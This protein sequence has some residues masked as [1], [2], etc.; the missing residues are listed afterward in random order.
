MSIDKIKNKLIESSKEDNSWVDK[1]KYRKANESWLDISFDIAIYVM[2]VLKTNKELGIKPKTQKDLAELLDCTPQ[3]VNKI[4]KGTEKLQIDTICKI[5]NILK[6]KLI[7]ITNFKIED[8]ISK[9]NK[10]EPYFEI[11]GDGNYFMKSLSEF[12]T[13]EQEI[14]INK[15]LSPID[16]TIDELTI[17]AK[18]RREAMINF[19]YKFTNKLNI[20]IDEIEKVPAYKRMMISLDENSDKKAQIKINA[21]LQK[22]L[23]KKINSSELKDI[24]Y[25]AWNLMMSELIEEIDKPET[26]KK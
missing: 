18:E 7:E 3:Y 23:Q 17:R 19:N 9:I 22:K 15:E 8:Y 6:I 26:I 25:K 2:S 14:V 10:Q 12:N 11:K 16:L 5:E 24:Y 1:A 4:L 13:V 21:E 20:N